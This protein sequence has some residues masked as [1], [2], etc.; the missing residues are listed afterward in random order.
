MRGS[1]WLKRRYATTKINNAATA[2]TVEGKRLD[3]SESE[4]EKG[5][6][7]RT[8]SCRV[9]K[10]DLTGHN[11]QA[12][13]S[14]NIRSSSS[15]T[16]KQADA[17]I[18][19]T[20]TSLYFATKSSYNRKTPFCEGQSLPCTLPQSLPTMKQEDAIV[21]RTIPSL[22]FATKSSYIET[23]RHHYVKDNPSTALC[24]KV[25]LHWNR[26]T[27]ICEGQSLPCTLPQS[28]PTLKQEDTVMW[29][30]IPPLHFA[31]KSSYTE[32][33]LYFFDL[34]GWKKELTNL[35][36]HHACTPPPTH[37]HTHTHMHPPHHTHNL[38]QEKG[39]GGTLSTHFTV[40]ASSTDWDWKTEKHRVTGASYLWWFLK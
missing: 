11:S 18:W 10:L 37:T 19:R 20:F 27:P 35:T 17:V 31:T 3:E 38:L 4:R 24:Y 36:S 13:F 5:G 9:L 2:T 26:K 32:T 7:S 39:G 21:W 8:I 22:Y 29:R 33:G 30:T 1:L 12:S 40:W 14:R 25:F 28:L 16:L 34:K 6:W 23:G 15:R